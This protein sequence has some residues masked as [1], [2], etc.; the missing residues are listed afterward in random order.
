MKRVIPLVLVSIFLFLLYSCKKDYTENTL[1]NAFELAGKNRKELEKV[2]AYYEKPKYSLKLKAAQFLIKNMVNKYSYDHSKI[3]PH[4]KI[5]SALDS[6]YNVGIEVMTNTSTS[7]PGKFSVKSY[8]DSLC[9]VHG[10]LNMSELPKIRDVEVIT[11]NFLIENI[12]HAFNIWR[13]KPWAQHLSFDEFCEFVLPYRGTNEPLENWRK[14]QH[15]KYSWLNDLK[16]DDKRNLVRLAQIMNDSLKWFRNDWASMSDYPDLP[17]S[18]L[19]DA[20]V[21]TCYDMGNLT[22]YAMRSQG[23]PVA[24]VTEFGGHSWNVILDKDK[25]LVDFQGTETNP[26]KASS[27]FN[28]VYLS[29]FKVAKVYMMTYGINNSIFPED[30]PKKNIPPFFQRRDIKDVTG[31]S[32]IP[33]HKIEIA[34]DSSLDGITHLYLCHFDNGS[35]KWNAVAVSKIKKGKA[36][37]MDMGVRNIYLPAY[38]KNNRYVPAAPPVFLNDNGIVD[39]LKADTDKPHKVALYRKVGLND[40]EMAFAMAMQDAEFQASNDKDFKK[41]TT[42]FK[43]NDLPSRFETTRVE[44]NDKFRF[45]RYYTTKGIGFGAERGN[46]IAELSFHGRDG[47]LLCGT[48]ISNTNHDIGILENV[49]DENIRTNF[50]Y[51]GPFWIGLDLNKPEQI[52]KISYMFR[53]SFNTIEKG[54]TYELFYWADEWKSL[55]KQRAKSDVLKYTIPGNPALWLKNLT[56]GKEEMIFFIS[57]GKQVWG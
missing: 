44:K 39:V 52:S 36:S 32:Q 27:V 8:W 51:D 56:K 34:L 14:A 17:L 53:S 28:S 38:Y 37:F 31:I 6:A 43:I 1:K 49:F 9:Q 12:D 24:Q 26:T 41:Y 4:R 25:R 18:E 50:N 21:G 35:K 42:L 47:N 13:V 20:K 5:L 30:Y 55:G 46:G 48:P 16:E 11:S 19:Y 22:T 57:K 54:D 29:S 15:E 3:G 7:M 40:G 45:V 23:I 2:I 10:K 33:S